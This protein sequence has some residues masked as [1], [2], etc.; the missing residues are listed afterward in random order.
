MT[1]HERAQMTA[2]ILVKFLTLSRLKDDRGSNLVEYAMLVALIALLLI[3]AVT[4]LGGST[5]AR[6][7]DVGSQLG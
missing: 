6:Y 4:S 2:A 7:S 1:A 3:A 5:A